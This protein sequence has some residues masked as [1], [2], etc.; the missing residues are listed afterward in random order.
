LE[1]YL[2]TVELRTGS[3]VLRPLIHDDAEEVLTFARSLPAHDLMFLRRDITD[4]ETVEHWLD[5]IDRGQALIVIAEIDG[6]MVGYGM[7]SLNDLDWSRHLAELRVLVHPD[8]RETGLG[9]TMIREVF[10]LAVDRGV[11][12]VIARMTL[13]QTA[14]RSLF[15]E[16]GFRPEALHENE[17]KDRSGELHDV[18]R[19][20]V[21]VKALLARRDSYGMGG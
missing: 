6:R 13:D 2:K 12:K 16:L 17:V 4:P 14:A 1:N 9:R 20:A 5:E 10:R 7:L 19:M 15:H 8:C 3:A 21:D 11:E 18:V